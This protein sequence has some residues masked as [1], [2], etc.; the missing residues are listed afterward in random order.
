M[1]VAQVRVRLVFEADSSGS[2]PP[3]TVPGQYTVLK[4]AF[5]YDHKLRQSMQ[6]RVL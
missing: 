4:H 1:R 2:I 6:F 3:H 5:S